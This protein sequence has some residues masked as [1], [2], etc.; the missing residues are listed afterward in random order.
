MTHPN[1]ANLPTVPTL[2]AGTRLDIRF[3]SQPDDTR[4]CLGRFTDPQVAF[5]NARITPFD[6]TLPSTTVTTPETELQ[7][8]LLASGSDTAFEVLKTAERWMASKADDYAVER[9]EM[10][11]MSDRV[12]WRPNRAVIIAAVDRF[13]TLLPALLQ[14]SFYECCLRKMEREMDHSWAQAE[15][16]TPLIHQV[17]G[18]DLQRWPDVNR[19]SVL[20]KHSRIR[21][22]RLE[23]RLE[24]APV[25][26]PLFGQR[27][28]HELSVQLDVVHRL[29]TLDDQIEVLEDLY[30][31]AT[32]R[33][34]EYR[35]FF[36]ECRLEIVIIIV[37]VMDMLVR[38]L[39][40]ILP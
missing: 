16:D 14:F 17:G 18:D 39:D 25:S 12:L 4:S 8:L 27:L 31:S 23:P 7:V 29:Q 6:G 13:D 36:W 9:V 1:Q 33:L 19:M 24:K 34:S 3:E 15:T 20:A 32:D 5:A 22:A 28:F 30:E 37:L 40:A 11:M 26:L 21:Y 38:F 35:Y 10:L 2:Q